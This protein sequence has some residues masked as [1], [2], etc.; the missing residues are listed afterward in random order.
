MI[1]VSDTTSITTALKAN[2]SRLFHNLSE[3]IFVPQGVWDELARFHD[4]LPDFISLRPVTDPQSRLA[5]THS[6]GQGEAEAIKLAKEIGADL[7]L[8]DDRKARAAA[9]RVGIP[10]LG[11]LGLAIH[12]KRKG[13]I[14]SVRDVV[15]VLEKDGGLYVSVEVKLEA[16]RI[17]GEA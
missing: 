6:L 17:A 12:A 1:V 4:S 7:L 9:V 16:F 5:E 15:S 14:E 11:L 13:R 2:E 10:C 3:K 8:T